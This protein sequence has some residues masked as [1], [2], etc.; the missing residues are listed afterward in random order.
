LDNG[1]ERMKRN[2]EAWYQA[3][4]KGDTERFKKEY[5][6]YDRRRLEQNAIR[7]RLLNTPEL[8]KKVMDEL[9]RRKKSNIQVLSSYGLV[10][11]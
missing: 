2:L 9:E 11:Q 1:E 8:Y 10:T 5:E 3:F 6:E 7:D 4:G